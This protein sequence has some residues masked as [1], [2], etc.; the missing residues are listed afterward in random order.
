MPIFCQ[1][2]KCNSRRICIHKSTVSRWLPGWRGAIKVSWTVSRGNEGPRAGRVRCS[3]LSM[4][5]VPTIQS[6]L[7]FFFDILP[8]KNPTELMTI[9]VVDENRLK[10]QSNHRSTRIGRNVRSRNWRSKNCLDI[11]FSTH[12]RERE[13]EWEWE[14]L[15]ESRIHGEGERGEGRDME[16]DGDVC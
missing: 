2:H 9:T 16:S 15:E 1:R 8:K 13:R 12:E 10:L 4:N 14:I 11:V 7:F 3:C 5:L 6:F